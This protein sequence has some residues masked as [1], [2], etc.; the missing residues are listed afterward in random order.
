MTLGVIAPPLLVA[1]RTG[2]ATSLALPLG[3]RGGVLATMAA[4]GATTVSGPL[5]IRSRVPTG[6]VAAAFVHDYYN[7]IH[8]RPTSVDFGNVANEVARS[9]NIWN[10]YL[11]SVTLTAVTTSDNTGLSASAGTLPVVI[12]PLGTSPVTITAA[13]DGPPTINTHYTFTFSTGDTP[14]LSI[15]GQRARL[16]PFPPNW[17]EGVEETRSFKTDII[18]SRSNREQRRAV[19]QTPRRNFRVQVT[20]HADKFRLFNRSL[21]SWQNQPVLLA[22]PVRVVALGSAAPADSD[23]VVLA[24]AAPDWLVPDV[25]MVMESPE[26]SEVRTVLTASGTTVVF[27][28]ASLHAWPVTSKLRP[29][30]AGQLD[31]SITST[32]PTGRTVEASISFDVTPASEVY[33]AGTPSLFVHGG[34]EVWTKP[35]NWG[36][37]VTTTFQWANEQV[38]TGRGRIQTYRPVGFGGMLRQATYVGMNHDSVRD[39]I[40]FFDRQRGRA[41]EFHMPTGLEDMVMRTAAEQGTVNLRVIG[42]EVRDTYIGD[43]VYKAI[44]VKMLDGRILFRSVTNLLPISDGLGDDTV[45]EVDAEWFDDIDPDDVAM[46]SWMPVFRFASDDLSVEWVTDTVAQTQISMQSLENLTAEGTLGEYDEAAQWV[47][48]VWG[49]PG[50]LGLDEFDALV[51]IRAAEVLV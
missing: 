39:L 43:P 5:S 31:Q 38:D 12:G 46:V 15:T 16:W 36:E 45:V 22:D 19:R 51:N 27:T 44:A 8:L 29:S 14:R 32:N 25:N 49:D 3:T 2:T 1:P 23:S 33:A 24:E 18:T 26:R 20:A 34:R 41:G 48:E 35:P 11:T 50:I 21:Q 37:T 13:E 42:T 10:A 4:A 9:V 28:S 30:L 40:Q 17:R 7:R 6:S 47:L